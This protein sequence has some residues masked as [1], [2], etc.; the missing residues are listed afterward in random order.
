MDI[1]FEVCGPDASD[2][3]SVVLSQSVGTCLVFR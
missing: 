3:F 2:T 1:W